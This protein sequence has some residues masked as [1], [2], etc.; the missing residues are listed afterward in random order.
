MNEPLKMVQIMAGAMTSDSDMHGTAVD[1][2][3]YVHVGK[4]QCM[5]IWTP[6]I[7]GTDTD[8]TYDCKL[9]ESD[10]VSGAATTVTSD[11]SDVTSGAFTQAAH[12]GSAFVETAQAIRFLPTKR[13]VN[14]LVTL[15]GTTAAFENHVVLVL[16]GRF[17]T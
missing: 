16:Q 8:E 9:Q 5:A 14:A 6:G 7:T 11:W 13:F 17:D 3:P 2:G 1:L 15:G 4:R 10:G 12:N